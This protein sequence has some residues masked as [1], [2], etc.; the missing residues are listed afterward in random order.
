MEI[1]RI[2]TDPSPIQRVVW[3][4]LLSW[5]GYMLAKVSA[6]YFLKAT[7]PPLFAKIDIISV[8]MGF[9]SLLMPKTNTKK[10]FVGYL[11]LFLAGSFLNWIGIFCR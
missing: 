1:K 5:I 9:A 10:V 2:F 11:L 6:I 7:Q 8:V 3:A 4:C